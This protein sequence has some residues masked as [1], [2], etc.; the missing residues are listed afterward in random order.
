[1]KHMADDVQLLDASMEEA[2][3]DLLAG[4]APRSDDDESE[5]GSTDDTEHIEGASDDANDGD[6]VIRGCACKF[7]S[8]HH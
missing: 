7:A 1:M 4:T 6:V 8:Q 2:V 3:D 5:G